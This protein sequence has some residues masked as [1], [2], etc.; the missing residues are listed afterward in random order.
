MAARKWKK[1]KKE[2]KESCSPRMADGSDSN[3]E[4]SL[5]HPGN[6]QKTVFSRP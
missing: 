1:K 2:F 6:L 4:I 5:I 3:S